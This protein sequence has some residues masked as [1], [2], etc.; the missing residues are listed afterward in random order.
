MNYTTSTDISNMKREDGHN[1]DDEEVLSSNRMRRKPIYT[2]GN[3]VMRRTSL[4]DID[5]GDIEDYDSDEQSNDAKDGQNDKPTEVQKKLKREKMKQLWN[6]IDLIAPILITMFTFISSLTLFIEAKSYTKPMFSL[7]VVSSIST[8]EALG[9]IFE[10]IRFYLKPRSF[11]RS[12]RIVNYMFSSLAALVYGV[13]LRE[14]SIYWTRFWIITLLPMAGSV[15]KYSKDVKW[16]EEM[17]NFF[18]TVMLILLVYR[19][20]LIGAVWEFSNYDWGLLL[21][22]LP[23]I[24]VE[25]IWVSALCP[26]WLSFQKYIQDSSQAIISGF[27]KGKRAEVA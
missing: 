16:P 17:S 26:F 14:K 7:W 22:L 4:L 6:K 13:I 1:S 12:D 11:L 18:G 19:I 8:G 21:L 20:T 23:L 24:Y 25:M 10:I 15:F 3:N 2:L 5:I 27:A 9:V